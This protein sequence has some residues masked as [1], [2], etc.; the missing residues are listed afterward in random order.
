MVINMTLK[1]CYDLMNGDYDDV[2]GRLLKEERVEKYLGKFLQVSDYGEL[3]NAV[4]EDNIEDIFRFAHNLK[5]ISMNLSFSRLY[6]SA[7]D[8]CENVRD[9]IKKSDCAPFIERIT[10]DY[11][12]IVESIKMYLGN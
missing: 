7:S 1:E 3:I 9:G 6:S 2:V 12:Q 4:K 11:N 5:G 8:L 10:A